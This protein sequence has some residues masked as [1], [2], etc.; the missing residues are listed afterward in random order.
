MVIEDFSFDGLKKAA[1][2]V[3]EKKKAA[4]IPI[5]VYDHPGTTHGSFLLCFSPH[6][7][8]QVEGETDADVGFWAIGFA[9]RPNL[10][11][12][13]IKLAFEKATQQTIDWFKAHL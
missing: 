2:G 4:G 9:A 11:D 1:E 7:V 10:N 12:P 5:A 6:L 13:E 3:L 8:V